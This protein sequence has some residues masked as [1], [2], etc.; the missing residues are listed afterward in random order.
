MS[1]LARA[2]FASAAAPWRKEATP[3]IVNWPNQAV[4][5]ESEREKKLRRREGLPDKSAPTVGARRSHATRSSCRSAARDSGGG[6]AG[7]GASRAARAVAGSTAGRAATASISQDLAS[8]IW[9]GSA[10][11][12][13]SVCLRLPAVDGR[14]GVVSAG[15]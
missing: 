2:K 8:S 6:A 7:S 15:L 11:R 9:L 1:R 5:R 4:V 10:C 13:D 12:G 3:P 14:T